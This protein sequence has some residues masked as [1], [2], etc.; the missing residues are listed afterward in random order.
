MD[1]NGDKVTDNRLEWHDDMP[2]STVFGDHFYSKAD[3]RAECAHVFLA[4]NDLPGRWRDGCRFTIAELGFG[5]GLNFL[6]SVR[7]WRK[8]RIAHGRLSFVSFEAFPMQ[9]AEMRR[10]L[11]AWPDLGS[12]AD[13]LTS[14]WPAH[15]PDV[16][17]LAFGEDVRL[18]VHIGDARQMV[19][20][21]E[22]QA[23]AW[24]L[25]GFSPARN[26]QMWSAELMQAV[27]AHT[28]PGGTFATYTAAGRVRRNLSAAGFQV[29]KAPGFAGKRDMMRGF[30]KHA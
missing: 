15:P 20:V 11:G 10:A 23:D 27:H 5:T 26:P 3:G 30:K 16:V 25:D 1:R 2:F 7:R 9:A 22:G 17:A 13:Q 4:G 21:W 19:P 12:L 14:A 24:F 18:E 28:G 6:E 29:D 8:H